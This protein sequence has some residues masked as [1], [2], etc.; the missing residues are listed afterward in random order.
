[1]QTHNHHPA[2]LWGAPVDAIEKTDQQQS[3]GFARLSNLT[4]NRTRAYEIMS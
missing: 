1:M 2:P 4:A 3:F